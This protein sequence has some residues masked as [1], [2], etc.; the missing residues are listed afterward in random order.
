MISNDDAILSDLKLRLDI[1]Y[2]SYEAC[3]AQGYE[4][5]LASQTE[6]NNPFVEGT[7]ESVQWQEGWWAGF[8]GEVPL[9]DLNDYIAVHKSQYTQEVSVDDAPAANDSHYFGMSFHTLMNVCKITGLIAASA[10]LG[11]QVLELVA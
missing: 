10:L 8:Y 9:Y 2:P 4:A 5:S 11:Y 6:E 7:S 1:Q 3:Y